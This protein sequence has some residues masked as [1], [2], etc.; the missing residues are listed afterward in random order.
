MT[1]LLNESLIAPSNK[2]FSDEI[3]NSR[4]NIIFH[5]QNLLR[6][7]AGVDLLPT[8][9]LEKSKVESLNTSTAE[10]GLGNVFGTI[11]DSSWTLIYGVGNDMLI[12]PK[13]DD[14]LFLN[15]AYIFKENSLER[16][17]PEAQYFLEKYSRETVRL[18]RA[19]SSNELTLWQIKDIAT[20][21]RAGNGKRNYRK[22]VV[23]FKP[24][25]A[26]SW[27]GSDPVAVFEVPRH[28]LLRWASKNLIGLGMV[29]RQK[30]EYELVF[31]EETWEE[32]AN[33]IVR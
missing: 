23:Y 7:K 9:L 18:Y 20:L 21:K 27:A 25:S 12:F 28:L 2:I 13:W 31:P 5:H 4:L 19:M 3:Y 26:W 14:F 6:Q 16:A 33:F 1:E 8:E 15:Y 32:L 30:Q 11:R 10:W 24:D 29:D 22:P 17:I